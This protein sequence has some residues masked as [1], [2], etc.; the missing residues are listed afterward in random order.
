V[1]AGPV[2]AALE[3]HVEHLELLAEPADAHP[4]LD[5]AARQ[6][7]EVGDLLGRVHRVALGDQADAGAQ[8][9]GVGHRRQIGQRGERLEQ[10]GVA[11]AG[12]LAVVGVRVAALVVVEQHH[13]LGDP[14]RLEPPLLDGRTQGPQERG[15]GVEC[16]ERNERADLHR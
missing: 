13:V 1:V 9:Q 6:H 16:A 4:E 15:V 10:T 14:H 8:P 7:V 11:P 12:E 2:A 5:P 3:R